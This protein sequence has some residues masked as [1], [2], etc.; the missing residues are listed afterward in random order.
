MSVET[1]SDKVAYA[2]F[3]CTRLVNTAD[4]DPYFDAVKLLAYQILHRPSTRTKLGIPLLVFVVPHV[5]ES[6]RAAFRS[7]GATVIEIDYVRWSGEWIHPRRERWV[8]QMCKLRIFEQ[9]DYDRILYL[10]ADMLLI[11]SL[12]GIW[13]EPVADGWCTT[14][15]NDDPRV[16]N[17]PAGAA[18]LPEQY[19]F[20][21]V[22]DSCPDHDRHHQ[23]P[24][25]SDLINGGFWL[26]SPSQ[27]LFDY[28]IS[29]ISIP[30]CFDSQYMEQGIFRHAHHGASRMPWKQFHPGKWNVNWPRIEDLHRGT[31]TLHEKF[32]IIDEPWVEPELISLWVE[33]MEEMRQFERK[34]TGRLKDFASLVSVVMRMQRERDLGGCIDPELNKGRGAKLLK[35]ECG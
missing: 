13:S 28:Y 30:G 4:P 35:L 3:Y 6:R 29:L 18:P 5:P 33:A 2:T 1:P 22:P 21:G 20:V 9:T 25:Q 17:E 27:Q 34:D 15:S 12:D 32:W 23:I 26:I 31:A 7:L 10:D 16:S 11:K 19:L 8:D 24:H 14:R